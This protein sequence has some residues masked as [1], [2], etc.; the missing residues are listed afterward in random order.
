MRKLFL[1][2]GFVVLVSGASVLAASNVYEQSEKLAPQLKP[3]IECFN[4]QAERFIL[5]F[6]ADLSIEGERQQIRFE[7]QRFDNQSM[8]C[9]LEHP[10][11]GFELRRTAQKTS[12]ILPTHKTALLGT[13]PVEGKETLA[14]KGAS[15]RLIS[16]DC[17]YFP[18]VA[19]LKQSTAE[20][21]ALTLIG[22]AKLQPVEDSPSHWTSES[23]K[24]TLR[25]F[26]DPKAMEVTT[27]DVKLRIER[28]ELDDGTWRNEPLSE[29]L[30]LLP[31]DRHELESSA[32]R[33]IRRAF[34]VLAPATSLRE[35]P[36]LPKTV[37]N[38]ELRWVADQRLV[39]LS[40]T[41]EQI[42]TAHGL[43]LSEQLR[44]NLDSVL[45]LMSCVTALQDG[46]WLWD[47]LRQAYQRLAPHIPEDHRIEA[48]AIAQAMGIDV[49][50]LR[51]ASVF[52]E[53]FHCSGFG[54]FGQATT[55]GKLYHG[56][57]LDYMTM[58]GLQDA[59]CVFV[60]APKGKIPFANIGYA[61][62]VGCVSGMN[63]E[64]ISLGEMGGG[65]EGKWDGV[66]MGHLMRKAME[67][68][69]TLEEVKKLW[70][71]SARTC[72][73]YY[74]FADGKIPSA[75]GVG[76]TPEDIFFVAPGESHPRLG[77]G[78][79]DTVILSAGDRLATLRQR[80]Q[81]GYGHIDAQAAMHLMD[82]PVAMSSSLHN[83]LFVPQDRVF[84]VA[85]ADHEN[86]AAERPYV[87]YDLGKLLRNLP[88]GHRIPA[89]SPAS[90]PAAVGQ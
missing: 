27:K 2:T 45:Y 44:R 69:S 42:G 9:L 8:R 57:I 43:L 41:P 19:I 11:Y 35:P 72:E 55:D 66:P 14:P 39:L 12:V 77:E 50:K 58:I 15:S 63:A 26:D 90:E 7:L 87:R 83:V 51:L 65:G 13:G 79:P 3:F 5:R 21:A 16:P 56:R 52:P 75:V 48:D 81:D 53:L 31:V 86:N 4:G 40:G 22:L 60:V 17:E 29:D 67:D 78:I 84:F 30:T 6:Q 38:G 37:P 62:Y 28:R 34:E 25:F 33:G 76:A 20:T 36:R 49:E 68:C 71:R 70:S 64:Q 46:K 10:R 24:E 80:V 18:F 54:L 1:L 74:V 89:Q 59:A 47:E 23:G 85:H 88:F 32:V 61:G 82:R 73:Y